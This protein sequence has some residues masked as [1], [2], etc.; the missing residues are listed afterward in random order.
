[1]DGNHLRLKEQF[2]NQ[3]VEYPRPMNCFVAFYYD[4]K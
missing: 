4:L 3:L 2:E 1:M